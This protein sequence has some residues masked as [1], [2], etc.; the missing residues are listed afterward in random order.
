[1]EMKEAFSCEELTS[2][3]PTTRCHIPE[4]RNLDTSCREYLKQH[5]G[6]LS[7]FFHSQNPILP[8]LVTGIM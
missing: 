5:L 6:L 7:L 1:M 2:N 8:T 4:K 3:R